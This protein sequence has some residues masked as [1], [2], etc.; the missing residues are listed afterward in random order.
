MRL[1]IFLVAGMMCGRVNGQAIKIDAGS[2]YNLSLESNVSALFDEQEGIDLGKGLDDFKPV[3]AWFPGWLKPSFFPVEVVVDLGVEH[4]VDSVAI[5]DS[6]GSGLVQVSTGAPGSWSLKVEDRSEKYYQWS[7]SPVNTKTRLLKISLYSA[8]NIKEIIFFGSASR[9]VGNTPPPPAM[10]PKRVPFQEFLGVNILV[11]DPIEYLGF[12]PWVRE[13]HNWNWDEGNEN[14]G[15]EA[16][17]YDGF[18]NNKPKWNPSYAGG[19]GWHFDRFYTQLQSRNI[20]I[21]PCIQGNVAWI[22]GKEMKPISA[23]EEAIQPISYQEHAA[24]L[25]QYAARYGS[26]TIP[27]QQLKTHEQERPKSGLDLVKYIENWNEPDGWWK[28]REEF[29]SPFEFAAML[30]ADYD[31][32]MGTIDPTTGIKSADPSLNVVMGGLSYLNI[33]YLK[34]IKLWSDVHREGSLPF[35]VVNLHHY[36]L[37]SRNPKEREALSPEEDGLKEK[38][39]SMVDYAKRDMPGK[40]VWLTEFGYDTNPRSPQGV[41]KIGRF[42]SEEVQA[43]WLARSILE[44][45][46]TGVDRAAMYMLRDVAVD[47]GRLYQ[48]SG[49]LRKVNGEWKPKAS[50]YYMSTLSSVMKDFYFS[51]DRSRNGVKI[52]DYVSGDAKKTITVIWSPTS[53]DKRIKGY[54]LPVNTRERVVNITRFS[55]TE[56][57]G[58]KKALSVKGGEVILEVNESPTFVAY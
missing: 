43:L 32:H 1:L 51:Q 29:F 24:H 56:P 3:S 36:S 22:S 55:S 48:S 50:W 10:V 52:Y 27:A 8:L 53:S 45:S 14:Y 37:T 58:T 18:P 57:N 35:D 5:Y 6:E 30:S 42:S 23:D 34:A 28:K 33:N 9:R 7:I 44:I 20:E 16:Y 2:V 46:T 17:D 19:G 49:L 13:Y 39:T 38:L 40:E 21:V 4:Q 26:S 47:R 41:D 12:T 54:K 31:G 15:Q 25:F 11:G